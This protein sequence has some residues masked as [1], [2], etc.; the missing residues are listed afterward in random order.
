M[1]KEEGRADTI[2]DTVMIFD[3][4]GRENVGFFERRH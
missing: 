1:G 3:Q 2:Y 4:C